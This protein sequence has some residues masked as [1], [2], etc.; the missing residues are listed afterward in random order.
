[1]PRIPRLVWTLGLV[2]LLMDLSSESVH[3]L[4]PLLMVNTLGLS[5]LD[6][7][8]IQGLSEASA[9]LIKIF[10]GALSDALGKRKA[11]LIW[12]YGIAAS[13]KPLFPLAHSGLMVLTARLLDRVG[14]GIRGAPRDAL[15]AD[16]TT[17]VNRG[18]AFGLRQSLDTVGAVLGP[19]LALLLLASLHNL[20]LTLSLA[21][22]PALICV[23]LIW[24]GIPK[25]GHRRQPSP[26]RFPL[27]PALWRE[28]SVRYWRVVWLGGL[29][30]LARFSEAFLLLKAQQVSHSMLSAPLAM[31]VM[32]VVYALGAYPAG[33]IS[34]NSDRSHLLRFGLLPLLLADVVLA[35]TQSNTMMMMGIALWGLHLALSEGLL[36]AMV[37]D[38][39]PSHLKGT[40]FGVFYL[41]CGLSLLLGNTVAGWL[42]DHHGSQA[43]FIVSGIM[44][45][46]TLL[47][48]FRIRWPRRG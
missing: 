3:S 4:L 40:A 28:F 34:D 7:G 18:A 13:S 33:R 45:L 6:V 16:V 5:A 42:W 1:M 39:T 12:G 8:L 47:L 14:K 44:T 17:S 23:G 46:L 22:I 43:L 41:V 32:N 27:H 21:I 36:S 11:L 10:S 38:E 35:L 30:S 9:L 29:I 2:S 25:D 26:F 24:V 37:A 20:R 15:V 31:V 19:L 48:T